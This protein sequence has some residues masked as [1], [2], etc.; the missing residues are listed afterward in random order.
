MIHSSFVPITLP[1]IPFDININTKIRDEYW[2][3]YNLVQ[4]IDPRDNKAR[5][6]GTKT[7]YR[8][9]NDKDEIIQL[10]GHASFHPVCTRRIKAM[11]GEC[12]RQKHSGGE[13]YG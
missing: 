8:R 11:I 12:N 9:A 1:I 6:S 2:T 4:L 13:V 3:E 7:I 10:A 5:K